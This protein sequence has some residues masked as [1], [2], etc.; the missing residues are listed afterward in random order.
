[1]DAEHDPLQDE[2]PPGPAPEASPRPE[3]RPTSSPVD[4][5]VVAFFVIL[6]LVF[7]LVAGVFS[8]AVLPGRQEPEED[9]RGRGTTVELD[10]GSRA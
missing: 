6:V 5:C 10:L 1:M 9:G 7:F 8:G 4:G 2:D 3:G